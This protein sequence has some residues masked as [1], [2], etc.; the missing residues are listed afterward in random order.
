MRDLLELHAIYPSV[1]G[2]GEDPGISSIP[3]DGNDGNLHTL[4]CFEM[5]E[6]EKCVSA[7]FVF[8]KYEYPVFLICQNMRLF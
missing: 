5:F 6:P 7:K 3:A 4:V 8:F 1:E 2:F